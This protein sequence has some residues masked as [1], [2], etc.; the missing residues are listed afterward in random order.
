[1]T[2]PFEPDVEV[3][4]VLNYPLYVCQCYVTFRL[5]YAR[6]VFSWVGWRPSFDS[7]VPLEGY[8]PLQ[9]ELKISMS[10]SYDNHGEGIEEPWIVQGLQG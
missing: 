3:V 10:I 4:P 1:M 9:I 7:P 6:F 2:P 5:P 8:R